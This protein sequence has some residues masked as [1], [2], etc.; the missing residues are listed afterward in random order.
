LCPPYCFLIHRQTAWIKKILEWEFKVMDTILAEVADIQNADHI[1]R[2][3]KLNGELTQKEKERLEEIQRRISDHEHTW[4]RYIG[5]YYDWLY[6]RPKGAY[7]RKWDLVRNGYFPPT[8]EEVQNACKSIGGCCAYNCGC[9][10]RDRGSSRMPGIVMHCG[11]HC[12][13]CSQRRS[14][15]CLR[16]INPRAARVIVIDYYCRNKMQY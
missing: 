8:Q 1:E 13:C 7:S 6:I 15:D 9:C 5:L 12:V 16:R 4:W 3:Q 2:L 11:K 14:P 10:Y